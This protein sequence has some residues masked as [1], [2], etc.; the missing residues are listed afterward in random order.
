MRYRREETLLLNAGE[1]CRAGECCRLRVEAGKQVLV[2]RMSDGADRALF[3][4]AG[5]EGE[6]KLI[7][8]ADRPLR[9]R[10]GEWEVSLQ[11]N[12]AGM[13]EITVPCCG[14]GILTWE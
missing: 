2:S 9:F 3:L 1:E 11:A 6:A 5:P 13:V 10:R 12:S 4:A 7:V 8:S 14:G